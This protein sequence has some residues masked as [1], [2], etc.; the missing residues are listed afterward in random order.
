MIDFSWPEELQ[1]LR[2]SLR[3][4]LTQ[5]LAPWEGQYQAYFGGERRRLQD[6]G[7]LVPELSALLRQTRRRSGE[8]GFYG[9]QMPAEVGGGGISRV[10]V[11]MAQVEAARQGYG[12][13]LAVMAGPEGAS[14]MLLQ[15]S[16][17]LKERYLGPLLHGE[18]STCFA[19]SEPEAGSDIKHLQTRAERQGDYYLLNGLKT[20][21]TNAPYADSA[22]VFA[23]T[24]KERYRESGT[25]GVTAF[26]VDSRTPG[27]RVGAINRSILDDDAQAELIF[28]DC[29]VPAENVIGQPGQGFY[30]AMSWIGIG[31]LNLAALSVGLGHYLLERSVEYARQRVTFGRPIAKRQQ[32]RRMLAWSAAELYAAE[33]MALNCAWRLDQGQTIIQESSMVKLY[34]TNML[35]RLADRAI[36]VHGAMG[37]MQ[38]LPLERIWKL[39][40]VL[41]IVEGTDEIQQE[42][43]AKGLGLG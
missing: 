14:P 12:L 35:Y 37:V 29:Q 17:P 6:D 25:V 32:I 11:F 18:Q 7:R 28:A 33:Q 13:N 36:Q 16:E 2:R 34:A 8:L 31:R 41:R 1:M 20:F 19:L 27:Y 38:E 40:R 43:I 42:T 15:L 4:F 22:Q 5:E 30:A 24:D 23:V 10:G 26:L 9:M 3:G 21:I 39:A